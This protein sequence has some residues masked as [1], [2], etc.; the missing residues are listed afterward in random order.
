MLSKI[1]VDAWAVFSATKELLNWFKQQATP[2]IAIAGQFSLD[3]RIAA[4]APDNQTSIIEV[5]HRLVSAGHQR[6]SLLTRGGARPAY[7]VNELE[8]NGIK[9]GPYNIPDVTGGP[10]EFIRRLDALFAVT[11]P[12]ALIIDEAS[13]FIAVRNHLARKGIHAPEKISLIC[14]GQDPSFQIGW[15]RVARIEWDDH[16]LVRRITKWVENIAYGK[17]DS[18]I[19]YV[20]T[21]FINGDTIGPVP[22]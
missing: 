18:R 2:V 17:A 15:P 13:T 16:A 1:E 22:S 11:P 12:T 10:D 6:I 8:A 4:V 14:V 9:T 5:V 20:K 21:K 19:T 7:F 3:M